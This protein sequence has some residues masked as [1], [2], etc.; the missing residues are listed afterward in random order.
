MKEYQ[1]LADHALKA[2]REAIFL[3]QIRFH[4]SDNGKELT[5]IGHETET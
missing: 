4:Y 5:I 1:K 2:I 3:L